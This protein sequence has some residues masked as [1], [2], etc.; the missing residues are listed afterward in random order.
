MARA[1][2]RSSSVLKNT[3]YALTTWALQLYC[4]LQQTQQCCRS[5]P[6]QSHKDWPCHNVCRRC[7]DPALQ[8]TLRLHEESAPLRGDTMEGH[9]VG[10][11]GA[12]E[13]Q[14]YLMLLSSMSKSLKKRRTSLREMAQPS[15]AMRT[16]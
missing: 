9:I 4:G 6:R 2:L 12:G 10:G 11:E 3:Q 14:D 1:L 16:I 5:D 15:L 13:R 8:A 7:Y